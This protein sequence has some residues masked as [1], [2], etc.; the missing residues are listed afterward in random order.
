MRG[1]P[2]RWRVLNSSG[3]APAGATSRPSQLVTSWVAPLKC[4][5]I[6]PPPR[7]EA[8][9]ST[10]RQHHLR[11]NGCVR[12]GATG[13]QHLLRR[14]GGHRDGGPRPRRAASPPPP[15]FGWRRGSAAERH[16]DDAFEWTSPCDAA[17]ASGLARRDVAVMTDRRQ[18]RGQ[19][20]IR[21]WA[22]RGG[23]CQCTALA[24]DGWTILARRLR[25][26]A[27]EIDL[28]AERNG[29]LALVEVKARPSLAGAAI[30]LGAHSAR[31]ADG[32]RR[33]SSS[34]TIRPGA[35]RVC[36]STSCWWMP[37]ARFAASPTRSGR[38]S[39]RPCWR[40]ARRRV[41]SAALCKPEPSRC[42]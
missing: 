25:T 29:L 27:G 4:S 21:A 19:Y 35:R 24:A 6:D 33:P 10:T 37:P 16:G 40:D 13:V 34:P 3:V 15:H 20:G 38:S 41:G 42:V 2:C 36:G 17:I 9:G 26:A 23:G 7:P 31:P 32:R 12:R 22:C 11:R 8:C 18:A 28:V 39:G 1:G 30:A 14:G 5:S